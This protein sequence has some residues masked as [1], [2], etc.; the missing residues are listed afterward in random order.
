MPRVCLSS[1]FEALAMSLLKYLKQKSLPTSEET[2]LGEAATSEANDAVESVLSE[3][4]SGGKKRKY[5]HFTPLQ[6]AKIAK[7]ASECGN[8]AAVRHFNK[9]F[10]FLGE[11]TVRVFKKQYIAE[12]KKKKHGE[13]V[14]ELVSKKRGRPLTLGELDAKVQQYVKALRKA[15]TPVNARI[16]LAAAKGIVKLLIAHFQQKMVVIYS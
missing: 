10:P 7:Y 6:R 2:G 9:D 12:L 5:T 13:D 11:S 14:T 4:Q 1:S 15:G 16:V 3:E 8:T